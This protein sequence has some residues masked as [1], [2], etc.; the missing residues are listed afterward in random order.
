VG[1]RAARK[2]EGAARAWQ[3]QGPM[4]SPAIGPDTVVTLSY[5]LFNEDG[6]AVD[7]ASTSEPLSYVHGYA[8]ILPGLERA[9]EGLHEG[10][11]RQFTIEPSDAFGDHDDEGVFEVDK[12]DIPDSEHVVPGDE[13]VAQSPD[14][15]SIS[16]RVVE[17][18]PDGF[19]VDTNH[20]LA[21]QTVKFEVEVS[22]VRAA[23]EE[24][25]TKA[26][27]E[28]EERA[29]GAHDGCC[30]HEHDGE[31]DHTHDHGG[32]ESGRLVQLS[33]KH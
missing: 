29:S 16:M 25:I 9:L 13:F 7:R 1:K 22:S 19:V 26:Q 23:S 14:G 30:D 21:G 20:P 32:E 31:H 3:T 8:Q 15:E 2:L 5:V 6:E 24:E 18:L 33:R 12:A 10:D 11:R 17:V 4:P 28:L 27:A